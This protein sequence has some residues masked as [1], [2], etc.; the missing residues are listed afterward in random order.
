MKPEWIRPEI[1]GSDLTY[2]VTS[3]VL[4]EFAQGHTVSDVLRELTQNEY[5]AGGRSLSVLFGNEALEI[6]GNGRVIG[7]KA[8]S[9]EDSPHR[10]FF[11]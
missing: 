10:Q 7:S 4:V 9:A 8:S 3:S 2:A 5:D 1:S 6:H 11:S